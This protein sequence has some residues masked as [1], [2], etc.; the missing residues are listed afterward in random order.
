MNKDNS[1][2]REHSGQNIYVLQFLKLKIADEGVGGW[3]FYNIAKGFNGHNLLCTI[4]MW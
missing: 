3:S 2:L 1:D 4:L